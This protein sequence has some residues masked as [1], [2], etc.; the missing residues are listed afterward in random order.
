MTDDSKTDEKEEQ[1]ALDILESNF[2]DCLQHLHRYITLTLVIALIYLAVIISLQA[3]EVPGV[4]VKVEGEFAFALLAVLY[5]AVGAMATYVA[6][7][8]NAIAQIIH[9]ERRIRFKALVLHPSIG[10]TTVPIVRL[11]VS[12]VPASI[13]TAHLAYVGFEAS[14]GGVFLPIIFFLS[15]GVTLWHL[16]PVGKGLRAGS[17]A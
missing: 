14:N 1:E 2:K 11:L 16:L 17:P 4:P 3:L 6:E 7:R 10:T 12:F 8:A 5:V 13:F 15:V 9:A